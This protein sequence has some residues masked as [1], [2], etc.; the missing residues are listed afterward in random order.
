MSDSAIRAESA[1]VEDRLR[2]LAAALSQVQQKYGYPVICSPHPR[3]RHKM[4][5]HPSWAPDGRRIVFS[6]NRGGETNSG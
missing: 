5:H 3:T 4:N 6:S 2:D 1:H